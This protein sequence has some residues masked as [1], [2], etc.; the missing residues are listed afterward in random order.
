MLHL[1]SGQEVLVVGEDSGQY[2]NNPNPQNQKRSNPNLA[3]INK[4]QP[5]PSSNIN[6][7]RKQGLENHKKQRKESVRKPLPEFMREGVLLLEKQREIIKHY[8]N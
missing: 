1:E 5:Q 4:E 8:K 2:P 7:R 3:L 6:S